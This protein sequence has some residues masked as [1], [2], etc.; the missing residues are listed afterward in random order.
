MYLPIS[1]RTRE[2]AAT[3]VPVDGNKTALVS[4]SRDTITSPTTEST[5]SNMAMV[6]VGVVLGLS[7]LAFV[8]CTTARY[9]RRR[10]IEK[11]VAVRNAEKHA[12]RE[13]GQSFKEWRA[14]HADCSSER[15]GEKAA[16]EWENEICAICLEIIQDNEPVYTL[17]CRHI[18]HFACAKRWY[19][20]DVAR[21]CPVCR[22]GSDGK[23]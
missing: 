17:Q 19:S 18:F 4:D 20:R 13:S 8:L 16:R 6:F 23:V 11:R 14:G 1:A 3:T 12:L 2:D 5:R 10:R 7:F 22:S 15:E 9:W 21:T